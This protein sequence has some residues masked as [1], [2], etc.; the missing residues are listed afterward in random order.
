MASF[1]EKVVLFVTNIPRGKVVSYGQVAS[2]C[3]N[4]R[5]ARAVGWALRSLPESTTIPW[6]RVV[7][8]QGVISIKGNWTA[9]KQLQKE[10]LEQ[11]NVPVREDL[12]LDIEAYR[13]R[14][15]KNV[16]Q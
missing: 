12:T 15:T 2:A 9:T 5:G 11:E 13:F 14:P 3:G 16:V 10:L 7:N 8:S 1:K 4:P 6:W